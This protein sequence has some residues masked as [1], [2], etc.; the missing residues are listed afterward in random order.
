PLLPDEPEEPDE[1]ED[2]DEPPDEPPLEP[3]DE[4]PDEPPEPP[5]APPPPRRLD[6]SECA[7][8]SVLGRLKAG[9]DRAEMR[10][11]VVKRSVRRAV[12]CIVVLIELWS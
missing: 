1:P 3:P 8:E 6:K 9:S 2:P 5:L 10:E 12:G 7:M 11:M 4:P